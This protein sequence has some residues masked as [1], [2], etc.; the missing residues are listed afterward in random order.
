M[1]GTYEALKKQLTYQTGVYDAICPNC[2]KPARYHVSKL[3]K[4]TRLQY[5]GRRYRLVNGT[6]RHCGTHIDFVWK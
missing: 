6:C 1:P 5:G 2:D 4:D 3:H